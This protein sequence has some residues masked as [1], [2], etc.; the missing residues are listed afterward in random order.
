MP[1]RRRRRVRDALASGACV[2]GLVGCGGVGGGGAAA[3]PEDGIP[4]SAV[5]A[6]TSAGSVVT[7]RRDS[8]LPIPA[9]VKPAL[10]AEAV[11]QRIMGVNAYARVFLREPAK[12]QVDVGMYTSPLGT[13][14]PDA[15]TPYYVFSG[16]PF[17]CGPNQGGA[18]I[19]S[20]PPGFPTRNPAY[21][22]P[23]IN[24]NQTC[25]VTIVASA[26]DGSLGAG[27]YTAGTPAS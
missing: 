4:Q 26:K 17:D 7:G 23:T 9:G 20:P 6:V 19:T 16:G 1:S 13:P 21:P 22:S 8:L 27:I 18:P 25:Y 2:F 10:T 15:T 12:L 14:P 5:V 24:T 3:S 11:R